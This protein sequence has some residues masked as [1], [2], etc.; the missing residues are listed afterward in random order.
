MYV[1]ALRP[2]PTLVTLIAGVLMASGCSA[3]PYAR[4][5]SVAPQA[6]ASARAAS[7]PLTRAQL[8]ALTFK[9]GEVAGAYKDGI[10]VQDPQPKEERRSFP[11]V[12][13]PDC[14]TMIDI[15]GGER[16][17]T[18][19]IQI[20]NWKGDIWAGGSTL[21]AYEDG[22]AKQAFAQLNGPLAPATRTRAQAGW[23][24]SRPG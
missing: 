4:P 11:P 19:V 7:A 2:A 16:S 15:R 3:K 24:S 9:E 20:F 21:A 22:K 14:Q 8:R 1:R 23:G 5:A 13:D 6:T 17:S 10:P 18:V 12:S